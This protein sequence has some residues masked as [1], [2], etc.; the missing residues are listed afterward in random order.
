MVGGGAP[1]HGLMHPE[2]GHIY[3]RRLHATHPQWLL[4]AAPRIE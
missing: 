1:I 3:P 2:I 4:D